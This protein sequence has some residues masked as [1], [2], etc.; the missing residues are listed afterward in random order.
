[1]FLAEFDPPQRLPRITVADHVVPVAVRSC[2]EYSLRADV[3]PEFLL[4]ADL[5]GITSTKAAAAAFVRQT[6]ELFEK[7]GGE[8]LVRVPS[9]EPRND[10]RYAFPDDFYCGSKVRI[11]TCGSAEETAQYLPELST[12]F[13]DGR[14]LRCIGN[15]DEKC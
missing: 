10:I 12:T 5:S 2:P 14:R 15:R 1:M 6:M 11:V 4:L 7:K 9:G 3:E 8:R 13:G